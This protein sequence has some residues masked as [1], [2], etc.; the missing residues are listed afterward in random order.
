M[1]P[2]GLEGKNESN[3]KTWEAGEFAEKP[4]LRVLGDRVR[5]NGCGGILFFSIL[6]HDGSHVD[7]DKIIM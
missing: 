5:E 6:Y 4:P 3:G 2:W 1:N 7:L